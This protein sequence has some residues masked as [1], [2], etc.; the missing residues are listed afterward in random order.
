VVNP[1]STTLDT[2]ATYTWNAGTGFR[3]SLR[4]SVKNLTD[5]RY[6]SPNFNAMDRRGFYVA[7]TLSH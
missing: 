1:A 2:G 4:L 7:Y 6:Y 5:K 3:H